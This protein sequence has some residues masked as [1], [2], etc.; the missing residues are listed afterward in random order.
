MKSKALLVLI[1]I[2]GLIGFTSFSRLSS[3]QLLKPTSKSNPYTH[4]PI[5]NNNSI[6]TFALG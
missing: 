1:L 4:L 2:G 6:A 5:D 3:S